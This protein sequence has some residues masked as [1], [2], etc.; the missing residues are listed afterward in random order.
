M[1]RIFL[2]LIALTLVTEVLAIPAKKGA[3]KYVQPDGSVIWL[4]RHGDEFFHWTTDA[5]TG[6]AVTR[7]ESGFWR[8]TKVDRSAAR[9][10]AAAR[11]QVNSRR[12]SRSR[13]EFN[14]GTRH[15]P[16]LMVEFDDVHFTVSDPKGMFDDLLNQEGYSYGGA[17]GSVR[18]YFVDN[19][20]GQFTPVFDI[21]G[22]VPL[23]EPMGHYGGNQGGNKDVN[24][25][26]A[27]FGA[28]TLLDD[29][30]DFSRYDSDNDGYV[31]MFLVYYAGFNEAEGG[32]EDSI[33]P[34]QGYA[35]SEDFQVDGLYLYRYF[36]TSELK[37]NS[38]ETFCSIGATCH[39]FSHALGLPDFYDTDY[40]DNGSCAGMWVF[41]VMD[42]GNYNNQSRT[43]PYMNSEERIMLG[44]MDPDNVKELPDGPVSFESVSK[45]VAYKSFTETDGEYFLYE[46][47]DGSS[48][49]KPIGKG[50]IA[51]HVDRSSAHKVGGITCKE[52]WDHWEWYNTL[53]AYAKHPCFY[54]VPSTDQSNLDY[55]GAAP[56]WMFPYMDITEYHPID[57][58]GNDSGVSL[59]DIGY[60]DASAKVTM[61]VDNHF[62]R[63]ITGKVLSVDGTPLSGVSLSVTE[64]GSAFLMPRK[65]MRRA[66]RISETVTG[67]DGSFSLNVKDFGREARLSAMKVGYFSY[68]ADIALG[69]RITSVEIVLRTSSETEGSTVILYNPDAQRWGM[70]DNDTGTEMAASLFTASD[71]KAEGGRLL[72]AVQY[73]INADSAE[74]IY[75][76]I[77]D[78]STG[79][80]LLTWQIEDPTYFSV[81]WADVSAAG[82]RI[83]SGRD[84]YIGY[85]IKSASYKYPFYA[86]DGEGNYYASAYDLT[87]SNWNLLDNYGVDLAVAIKLEQPEGLVPLTGIESLTELGIN[88]ID[89]GT[90]DFRAGETL[91]LK[92]V[93]SPSNPPVS[94]EW[95]WDGNPAS[96]GS[97]TLTKGSHVVSVRLQYADGS[98]EEME[99]PVNVK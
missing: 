14:F 33:W 65:G 42:Q 59:L 84:L 80:R 75:I 70:S 29:D 81:V 41:S 35:Y 83:P 95:F 27:I 26:E 52:Q 25:D 7:D 99:M 88:Y 79:E 11:R 23:P 32:P 24:V 31:D 53:N 78:A 69:P 28:V 54:V 67:D 1:K 91:A 72:S 90:G 9:K 6:Q 12:P 48:W 5:N 58:A 16:V 38:G 17:T 36:C 98:E 97:V 76:I 13:N 77:D 22:P 56:R 55:Y 87:S 66:S 63:V 74:D 30:I 20:H 60:D 21:Y 8:A 82:F 61:V 68:E 18:D 34:H 46:C 86:F 10:A 50:M 96:E 85:A 73:G 44:W 71:L 4:E 62:Q 93:E 40:E 92:L 51:I 39:E 37:N 49:D 94:T 3:F 47:R 15:I 43:P 19:S 89:P 45:D 64:P 2:T 57:W